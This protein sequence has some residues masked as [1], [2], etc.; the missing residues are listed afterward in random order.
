VTGHAVGA[1]G[2]MDIGP[3]LPNAFIGFG[4]LV[5]LAVLMRVVLS[6][7][8]TRSTERDE[9][10]ARVVAL[11]KERAELEQK[12]D[13][14]RQLTQQAKDEAYTAKRH[15]SGLEIEL[16]YSKAMVRALEL[17]V[18]RLRAELQAS[19]GEEVTPGGEPRD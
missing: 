4:V 12:L 19:R 14:T 6:L 2:G 11:L 16:E 15:K 13:D 3:L 18:Q 9:V 17:E 8:K 5:L 10:R 1:S 7:D